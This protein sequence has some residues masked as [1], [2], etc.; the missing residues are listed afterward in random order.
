MAVSDVDLL[1]YD[2]FWLGSIEDR[3][4]GFAELRANPISFHPE[5]KIEPLPDGPGYWAITR[6]ADIVEISR[7]PDDFCSGE[8]SNITT[9]PPEFRDFFGS[10]I[11]MDDPRHARLRKLVSA[12]FTPRTLAKVDTDVDR[13]AATIVDDI[14]DRGSCDF[15]TD[16]AARLPLEIICE[17]MAV[18]PSQYAFVFDQTNIILSN[19]DPE[20]IPPG[21]DVITAFLTAGAN[22]A[23][24]MN[25]VAETRKGRDGDDLTTALVN[26]EIDG[27]RLSR[28]EL[29]SFFVLLCAAGNE[30]TR[31]AISWGLHLLTENPEQYQRLREDFD[32]TMPTAVEEIVRVSSPVLHF[33]RTVTRDGVRLG[34]HEFQAGEKVVLWYVAGNRDES[35]F[36]NPHRFDVTRNPNNHLGFGGP[37]PHFC[38]GAH[39]ARREISVMFREL[40]SRLPDLHASGPPDRLRSHFINGIKHLPCEFTPVGQSS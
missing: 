35:I 17:M 9:T 23:E 26:A 27:D 15:V 20:F 25:D 13:I 30:T 18:P 28:E 1:D 33:R 4:A 2:N 7:R 37:G 5:P 14:S 21:E 16:V 6:H 24:L 32:A 19:G 38:L 31:N 40:T 34:D 3:D 22:L 10:M 36:E 39:L 8:G 29:Q 12:G 11:N